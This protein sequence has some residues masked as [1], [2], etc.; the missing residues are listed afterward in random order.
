M[1]KSKGSGL[2]VLAL[3]IGL[4]GAGLGGYTFISDLLDSSQ[5][6]YWVDDN[7]FNPSVTNEIYLDPMQIAIETTKTTFLYVSFNCYAY[8]VTAD[9]VTVR[10]F[11]NDVPVSNYMRYS[12]SGAGRSSLSLQYSNASLPAGSYTIEVWGQ[13]LDPSSYYYGLSLYVRTDK[14]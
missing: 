7:D 13:V 5:Q 1:A 10:I 11:I 8:F 3:L 9:M 4:I 12:A 6:S 2:V 14:I